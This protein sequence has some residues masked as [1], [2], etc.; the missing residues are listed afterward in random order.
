MEYTT[1]DIEEWKMKLKCQDKIKLEHS[2]DQDEYTSTR[3]RKR[4]LG[5]TSLPC[6]DLLITTMANDIELLLLQQHLTCRS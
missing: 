6:I 4:I 1:P 3:Q 5:K 2:P